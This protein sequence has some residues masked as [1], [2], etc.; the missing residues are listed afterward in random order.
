MSFTLDNLVVLVQAVIYLDRMKRS[1]PD[2]AL[3]L[4]GGFRLWAE[5][6]SAELSAR[7]YPDIRPVHDFALRSIAAGADSASE[8]GRRMAVSKQAAAKTIAVLEERGYVARENDPVDRR[9]RRVRVTDRGM[10]LLRDGEKIFDA[11]RSEWEEQVGVER[12][13]QLEA[14]LRVLVGTA[15]V[16]FD[17]SG[18]A[19]GHLD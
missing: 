2:L 8:L 11:L 5:R 16:R 17:T 14:D 4:F 18:G 13:A 19:A 7:G 3:L 10:A 15:I 9:R 1:G 12:V 6:G